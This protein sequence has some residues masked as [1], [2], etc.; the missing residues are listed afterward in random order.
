MIISFE[1]V[2][3]EIEELSRKNPDGFTTDEMAES[4]GR[5]QNW[6]RSQIK[7]LIR[8][9]KMRMNGYKTVDRIDGLPGR[10]P[11]YALT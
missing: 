8:A 4:T 5:T 6:C 9:K 1:E 10:A 7:A 2:L 11:V 3:K